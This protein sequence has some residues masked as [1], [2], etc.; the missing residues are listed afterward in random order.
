[1]GETSIG[2]IVI[3]AEADALEQFINDHDTRY[4][5][6][7]MDDDPECYV[8]LTRPED[9]TQLDPVYHV[10]EYGSRHIEPSDPGPTIL[11]AWERWIAARSEQQSI[12]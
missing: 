1:M 3:K 5:A 11:H 8:L 6:K 7:A 10:E 9:G 12:S 2:G 4:Q